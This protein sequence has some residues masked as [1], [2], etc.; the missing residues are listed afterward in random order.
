M[1]SVTFFKFRFTPSWPMIALTTLFILAFSELG[2]WQIHRAHEK[3]QMII[4]Q[5]NMLQ[6]KPVVWGS[7]RDL[8]KQYQSVQITGSYLPQLFLLDNQHHQHQFGYQVISPLLLQNGGVVLID[9]GWVPGDVS[10]KNFPQVEIPKDSQRVEGIAYFPSKKQWVLGA[11]IE[12]KGSHLYILELLDAKIV[13]QVLQKKVYPFIIRL[14]RN[15]PYGFIR[16]WKIV[17]MPPERHIAYAVQWFAMALVILILFI[18]LNLKKYA[19][20]TF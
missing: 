12:N 11:G 9:R 14:N 7:D 5:E 13:K 20:T 19:K 4:T 6:Q 10:R 18:A 16:E 3:Q 2:F 15:A 17:S 8:P 1:P